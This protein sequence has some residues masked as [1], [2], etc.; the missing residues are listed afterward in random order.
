MKYTYFDKLGQPYSVEIK[1]GYGCWQVWVDGSVEKAEKDAPKA[2][3]WA[4]EAYP[5]MTI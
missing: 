2:I 3:A 1:K 5:P 4:Y